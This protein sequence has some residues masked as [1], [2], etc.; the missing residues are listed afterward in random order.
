LTDEVK[1]TGRPVKGGDAEQIEFTYNDA[2]ADTVLRLSNIRREL[3][4]LEDRLRM[5]HMEMG[6]LPEIYEREFKQIKRYDKSG[7]KTPV[8]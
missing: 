3:E 4:S 8:T 6:M 2:V 7:S 1:Q 5:A